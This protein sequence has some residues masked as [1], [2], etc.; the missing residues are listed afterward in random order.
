MCLFW[1]LEK[2]Y[3]RYLTRYKVEC[4]AFT[5]VYSVNHMMV[6]VHHFSHFLTFYFYASIYYSGTV[7]GPTKMKGSRRPSTS[8]SSRYN[9][10]SWIKKFKKTL[11]PLNRVIVENA[12]PLHLVRQLCVE[13]LLICIAYSWRGSWMDWFSWKVSPW[14]GTW[15]RW[16]RW[17]CKFSTN[18]LQVWTV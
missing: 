13:P 2:K 15:C 11:H 14:R 4:I 5:N 10:Y 6:C 7:K 3:I 12:K 16:W 18:S 17:Y 8:K 1:T 9:Y